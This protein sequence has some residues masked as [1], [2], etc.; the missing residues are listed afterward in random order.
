MEDYFEPF[1]LTEGTS[2]SSRKD[3][4][5]PEGS[6]FYYLNKTLA[7]SVLS[8]GKSIMAFSTTR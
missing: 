3:A 1:S 8:L 6:E 7:A 4:A 5:L 2:Q